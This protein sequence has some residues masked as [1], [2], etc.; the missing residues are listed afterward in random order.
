MTGIPLFRLRQLERQADTRSPAGND[1]SSGGEKQ[2]HVTSSAR[3]RQTGKDGLDSEVSRAVWFYVN[4]L[5]TV[6]SRVLVRR[7]CL[8]ALKWLFFLLLP[9]LVDRF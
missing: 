9:H 4:S 5:E 7:F 8:L 6:S 3:P 1:V 2:R